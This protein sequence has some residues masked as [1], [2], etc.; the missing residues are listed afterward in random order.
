MIEVTI[1]AVE[2]LKSIMVD[3]DAMDAAL[4]VVVVPAGDGVQYMLTL[5][6]EQ[7]DD[8]VLTEIDGVRVLI[9]ADSAPIMEGAKIDYIEDLM[10]S[11]FIIDNPNIAM[12]TGGCGC[13]GNCSCG[14]H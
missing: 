9:D 2:K 6:S 4:R 1:E 11:G 12:S 8:D 13:G 7:N 5:E 14:G 3:E 10:R